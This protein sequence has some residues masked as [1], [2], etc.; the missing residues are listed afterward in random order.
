LRPPTLCEQNIEL[1]P[2][3]TPVYIKQ[4]RLPQSQKS[5]VDKQIQGMIE[6]GIIE[7]A[8]SAWSSP[9]LLVPK[10]VD[11]NGIKKWRIV[12]DYRKLNEKIQDDK[13]PL[14]NIAEILE[15]LSGSVYFYHLDLYQGYYQLGLNKESRQYTAF[16]TN[17]N[18]YQM[19]RLPMGLKISPHA[20]SRMIT[21][22]MSGL[23][24][25]QCLVYQ[26]DLICYGRS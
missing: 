9:L 7:E 15:S 23:N 13:F 5:E 10:K 25:E 8:R 11:T 20:F 17:K 6:D 21:I 18:Q 3:S 26:D 1:K 14:P 4:Y 22:A 12:I 24:F 16:T 19:T 2:N